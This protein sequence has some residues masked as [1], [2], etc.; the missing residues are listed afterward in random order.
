M[1]V[2][3]FVLEIVV[4]VIILFTIVQVSQFAVDGYGFRAYRKRKSQGKFMR[5]R[6]KFL[7]PLMV[8]SNRR[9]EKQPPFNE[10]QLMQSECTRPY[11]PNWNK[12]MISATTFWFGIIGYIMH[13]A[14]IVLIITMFVVDG[15]SF[16]TIWG[17]TRT[18]RTVIPEIIIGFIALSMIW[19]VL[20]TF[21]FGNIPVLDGRWDDD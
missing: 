9:R 2:L 18:E 3:W 6:L 12:N 14:I 19:H 16:I 10:I 1:N 21:V 11:P 5:F 20:G 17:H 4:I 15:Q 7:F 8:L 13:L